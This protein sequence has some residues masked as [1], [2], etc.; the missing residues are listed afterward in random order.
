MPRVGNMRALNRERKG[1]FKD[2]QRD[3]ESN[4]ITANF[5]SLL[6]IEGER[7]EWT[8]LRQIKIYFSVLSA[9]FV[10]ITRFGGYIPT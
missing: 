4:S 9:R 10:N 8:F 7:T 6:Y 1:S 5:S 2:Y 3:L